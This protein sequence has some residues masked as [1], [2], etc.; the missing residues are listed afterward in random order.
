MKTKKNNSS[1]GARTAKMGGLISQ[2]NKN[3]K[4]G[5]VTSP[6]RRFKIDY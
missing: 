1:K 3:Q 5:K 6:M 2:A 4:Y